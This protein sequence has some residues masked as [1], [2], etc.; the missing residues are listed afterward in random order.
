MCVKETT[1]IHTR[2]P[3]Y[4][5][6]KLEEFSVNISE[7]ARRFL[8]KRVRQLEAQKLVEELEKHLSNM[9][10]VSDSSKLIHEDREAR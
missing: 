8:E 3:R 6:E 1:V 5:K 10:R 4:V 7:E 9:P 2:V